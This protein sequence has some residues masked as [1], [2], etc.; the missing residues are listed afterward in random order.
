MAKHRGFLAELQYQGR[1]ADKRKRQQ[2]VATARVQ[3]AA[4]READRRQREL[5]RLNEA[6]ARASA[7]DRVRL[8]REAAEAY[9]QSR[10][11]QAEARNAELANVY[12]EIDGLLAAT[13]DVDDFVDLEA[14]KIAR[15]EQ[16][17]FDPGALAKEF[18]LLPALVYPTQPV[19]A[20]PPA[21]TGLGG[22]FGGRKKHEE[23]IARARADFDAAQQQWHAY[24]T[25]MHA[26]YGAAL[27]R[28]EAAEAD[29]VSSLA[30]AQAGYDAECQARQAHAVERNAALDTLINGLAFDVESAIND[31][32][33]IVLSN[34][35]YPESFR[36]IYDHEFALA[37]R[38]LT[39]TAHVP[40]PAA[41]PTVKE[42]RY[43]KPTD[44]ITA[45]PL[46]IK[47][48]K[49]RYAGA[50]WQV[51]VRTIHEVFEADRNGKI[52]TIALTVSTRGI[53]LATGR[54]QP[55]PLVIAAADRDTFA[56][57]DLANVVPHATLTHLGAALSKSPFD[58][59]P[60]DAARGVRAR[61]R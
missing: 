24:A 49:D 19:Y 32:V 16:P 10:I 4:Q 14:M 55:V 39:V 38:E 43:A 13:L 8:E 1:Q 60:A 20:E 3:A 50:V 26:E 27:Q 28:R 9:V 34:S 36:V 47:A 11:A 37:A 23:A 2:Q 18:P 6:M 52:R 35:V 40:S 41:I 57:F 51:A 30:V 33:D 44:E 59:N 21:P 46:T 48:Q 22:A 56:Q 58:L 53:N 5:V 7:A 15:I 61:G 25:Q 42:Y 29:R 45:S 54:E 17:P 12:G 31:Y